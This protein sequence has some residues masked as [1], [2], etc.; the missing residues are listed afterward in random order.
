MPAEADYGYILQ[1]LWIAVQLV[2]K[3]NG[4]IFRK[5]DLVMDLALEGRSMRV[6]SWGQGGNLGEKN[7]L[8][9][10]CGVGGGKEA[11]DNLGDNG[12]V[13]RNKKVGESSFARKIINVIFRHTRIPEVPHKMLHSTV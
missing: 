3:G 9:L 10:A 4:Y 12:I 1:R 2:C 8:N 5:H 13:E 11:Q 6:S 7:Q